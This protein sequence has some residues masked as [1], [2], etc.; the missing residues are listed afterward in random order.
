[1][2]GKGG[3]RTPSLYLI[4]ILDEGRVS[5]LEDRKPTSN[6]NCHPSIFPF[7][8]SGLLRFLNETNALSLKLHSNYIPL[9]KNIFVVQ[10]LILYLLTLAFPSHLLA[11]PCTS[12]QGNASGT[13]S[14]PCP[15][16]TFLIMELVDAGQRESFFVLIA[17][18]LCSDSSSDEIINCVLRLIQ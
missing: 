10:Q 2:E 1:M 6:I 14:F 3:F 13:I 7:G 18:S 12:K 5:T 17:N 8:C 9:I 4:F 15:E 11:F 16:K